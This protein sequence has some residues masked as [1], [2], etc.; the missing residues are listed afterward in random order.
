MPKRPRQFRGIDQSNESKRKKEKIENSERACDKREETPEHEFP[1]MDKTAR[2]A[3]LMLSK[4]YLQFLPSLTELPTFSEIWLETLSILDLCNSCS[5]DELSE[6]VPEAL[7]NMILVM[8]TQG[9]LHPGWT[10]SKSIN[11]KP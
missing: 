2:I 10:D 8:A 5:S 3:L 4:A 11:Q 1:E 6:A 9:I 7:K